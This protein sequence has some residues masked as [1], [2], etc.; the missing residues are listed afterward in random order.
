MPALSLELWPGK[1]GSKNRKE[2]LTCYKACLIELRPVGVIGQHEAAVDVALAAHAARWESLPVFAEIDPDS[3]TFFPTAGQMAIA[4]T[5]GPE[6][7]LYFFIVF[8]LTCIVTTWWFYARR[9]AAM[10]C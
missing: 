6:A 4:M 5:G 9:R 10:P 1:N 7:A 3:S 2:T 8:Y